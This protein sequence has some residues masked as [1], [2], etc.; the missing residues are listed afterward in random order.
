MKR[1]RPLAVSI[2]A[3][4]L[5]IGIAGFIG[6]PLLA[7]RELPQR[8]SA[9]LDRPTSLDG[10]RFNPLTLQLELRG[11]TIGSRPGREPLLTFDVLTVDFSLASITR[12]AAV[13]D[14][15]E[16]QA[17]RIAL[18][19]EP[20]GRLDISDIVDRLAAP[21]PAVSTADP[22]AP[23][24]LPRLQIREF[25]IRAGSIRFND[26]PMGL[27]HLAS[28]IELRL[29][30]AS[31]LP[32]DQAVP[33]EPDLSV[34]IDGMRVHARAS[35]PP[36]P[37]DAPGSFEL[38]VAGLELGR[39]ANYLPQGWQARLASARIDAQLKG[40]LG[41][42]TGGLQAD[43]AGAIAV[44][45]LALQSREG[46][47]LIAMPQV[48]IDITRASWPLRSIELGRIA[49]EKPQVWLRRARDGELNLARIARF[50]GAAARETEPAPFEFHLDALQIRAARVQVEDARPARPVHLDVAPLDIELKDLAWPPGGKPATLH[51]GLQFGTRSPTR[52]AMPFNDSDAPD[53]LADTRIEL[54]TTI[55]P[56]PAP[57]ANGRIEVSALRPADFLPYYEPWV[58]LRP[59]KAARIALS[60]EF[61]LKWTEQGLLGSFE[62]ASVKA[63]HLS[64]VKPD[65]G[66]GPLDVAQFDVDGGR[67]DLEKHS[68]ELGRIVSR[69]AQLRASRTADGRIDL[70]LAPAAPSDA[71]TAPAATD[72]RSAMRPTPPWRWHIGRLSLDEYAVHLRDEVPDSAVE[73]HLAP[74]SLALEDLGNRVTS[75]GRV[76]LRTGVNDGGAI[77]V[78]GTLGVQPF[79][80]SFDWTID[81]LG[82]ADFSPYLSQVSRLAVGA[83]TLSGTGSIEL[84]DGA[85]PDPGGAS[86]GR[87]RG[88]L[89]VEDFSCVE[90]ASGTELVRWQ[91]LSLAG[92]DATR[93]PPRVAIGEIALGDFSAG[94]VLG[95]NGRLN[96]QS[97][98]EAPPARG[99]PAGVPPPVAAAAPTTPAS[100]APAEGADTP[101]LNLTIGRVRLERGNINYTDL[102]IRPNF[103]AN[104]TGVSGTISAIGR[105]MAGDVDLRAML[106]D[107]A[108]VQ[109]IGK[110]NPLAR[111]LLLDLRAS[112]RDI[113]LPTITAYAERYLGYGIEKGSLAANLEY[114]IA[115]G[116]L[117]ASNRLRLDQLTF[118]DRVEGPDALNL[119]VRLAV[120][121]LRDRHGVIDI[122][123]P[124]SGSL[125]DPQFSVGRIVLQVLVNL[126]TK[127]VTAPFSMLA[128]MFGS[129][130]EGFDHID[131]APGSASLDEAA[132]TRLG[133]LAHALTERP[134]L[135]VD[136][137]GRAEPDAD[138]AAL[139][140][141]TAAPRGAPRKAL[142][143][144]STAI[145]DAGPRAPPVATTTVPEALRALANARANVARAWLAG[146]GGIDADR[147][148][149]VPP[150]L[151]DT[152][153]E[154]KA[155]G[156]RVDFALR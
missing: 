96:L 97:L 75:R 12:R 85:S 40:T 102:F 151:A 138:S 41:R 4:I 32:E 130:D 56:G 1:L 67:I 101:P 146:P 108:P 18:E 78:A 135:R 125:D 53:P 64:L 21:P 6:L 86:G 77:S 54:H 129:D 50:D 25:R 153:G 121:L 52:A 30:R 106:D 20:D 76:R 87:L 93:N 81:R 132:T 34:R 58:G 3:T 115:D 59:G 139:E 66:K 5:L 124:I 63:R 51:L 105:T 24:S 45:A 95:A 23:A 79:A 89:R 147:I 35:L 119:P 117:T 36:P 13:I 88:A 28:D 112:A 26:R 104:L 38:D 145:P 83:G 29:P 43:L 27:Q 142:S 62:R 14:R 152:A 127:A 73:L 155:T 92:I 94:L 55:T 134:S 143:S 122:D 70:G 149:L 90:S 16:L 2:V 57:V 44:D 120:A 19:R 74:L 80:G 65:G 113:Q 100:P 140:A 82:I 42:G 48:A 148:F 68:I 131:F 61:D 154:R 7:K 136:V 17:P 39:Y 47:P 31:T 103:R 11:L 71:P 110:V 69:G 156:P 123:L 118:G 8:I 46:E 9:A 10:I 111:P 91:T 37:G 144:A 107:A 15:I 128:S 33:L 137:T 72:T 126:I 84:P 150:R 60:S 49:I 109:V 98:E 99:Q 133:A 22:A 141:R 114:H 116:R